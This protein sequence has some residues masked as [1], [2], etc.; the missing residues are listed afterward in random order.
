MNPFIE[1]IIDL[2]KNAV[3]AVFSD[4][5]S[6][7]YRGVSDD[8]NSIVSSKLKRLDNLGSIFAIYPK[9]VCSNVFKNNYEIIFL[10]C[11]FVSYYRKTD[12]NNM[13]WD[14]F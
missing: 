6:H 8:G 12:R 9:D 7:F 11:L 5:G 2:D 10:L 3:V 1:K 4:H 13:D 14:T